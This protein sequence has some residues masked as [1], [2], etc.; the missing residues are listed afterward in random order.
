MGIKG[1]ILKAFYGVTGF[2]VKETAKAIITTFVLPSLI[3]TGFFI[4]KNNKTPDESKDDQNKPKTEVVKEDSDKKEGIKGT[5]KTTIA[6]TPNVQPVKQD[7][8]LKFLDKSRLKNAS[9]K[10]CAFL[11]MKDNIRI[12]DLNNS[13]SAAI[14]NAGLLP[15]PSFFKSDLGQY[16]DDF[17]YANGDVLEESKVADYID[18]YLIGEYTESIETHY[19]RQNEKTVKVFFKGHIINLSDLS[20]LPVTFE[21]IFSGTMPGVLAK[22]HTQLSAEIQNSLLRIK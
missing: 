20:S 2:F 15:K 1:S 5:Q 21:D 17:R 16:L 11:I 3:G 22:A 18:C 8:F 13:I 7:P 14:N 4:I 19:E 10:S 6:L 9:K 12:N